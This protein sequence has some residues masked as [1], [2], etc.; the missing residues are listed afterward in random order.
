MLGS[1]SILHKLVWILVKQL[2]ELLEH[3][4]QPV[5]VLGEPLEERILQVDG[6]VLVSSEAEVIGRVDQAYFAQNS[7]HEIELLSH[8][9]QKLLFKGTLVLYS[10]IKHGLIGSFGSHHLVK[11]RMVRSWEAPGFPGLIDMIHALLLLSVEHI[12]LLS[13]L[14]MEQD[15]AVVWQGGDQVDRLVQLLECVESIHP[16]VLFVP[17][18]RQEVLPED[19]DDLVHRMSAGRLSQILLLHLVSKHIEA[20]GDPELEGL[21]G[22]L[23]KEGHFRLRIRHIKQDV[24]VI[25]SAMPRGRQVES[26]SV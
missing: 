14:A 16:L 9:L 7:F 18:E 15:L 26:V 8:D 20:L 12:E 10:R 1:R 3:S 2:Y 23:L 6:G 21:E 11:V 17:V 13:G 22:I 4:A 24:F 25:Y 5:R 19:R